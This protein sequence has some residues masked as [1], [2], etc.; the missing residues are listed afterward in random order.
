MSLLNISLTKFGSATFILISILFKISVSLGA[1]NCTII[2]KIFFFQVLVIIERSFRV[3]FIGF[4]RFISKHTAQ[5]N[6][7]GTTERVE[8]QRCC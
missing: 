8:V 2:K 7:D 1:S 3:N 6:F 4:T 5:Y